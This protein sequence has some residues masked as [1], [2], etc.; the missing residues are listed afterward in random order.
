MTYRTT[1]ELKDA[2]V[3]CEELAKY[4]EKRSNEEHARLMPRI[5]EIYQYAVE[6][7]K[8]EAYL[9]HK[10]DSIRSQAKV[11]MGELLDIKDTLQYFDEEVENAQAEYDD[12][13]FDLEGDDYITDSIVKLAIGAR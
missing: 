10:L 5:D 8:L 13:L 6:A 2:V 1:Q 7:E 3:V 9:E 4:H 12:A 11:L